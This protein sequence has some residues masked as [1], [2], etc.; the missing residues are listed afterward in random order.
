MSDTWS[1]VAAA[2]TAILIAI[3]LWFMLVTLGRIHNEIGITSS[4]GWFWTFCVVFGNL[5][6]LLLFYRYRDRTEYFVS[7]V[8]ERH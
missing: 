7:T 8:F 2:G 6:G 5:F 4:W 3:L 1:Y